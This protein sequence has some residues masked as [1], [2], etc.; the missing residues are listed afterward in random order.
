MDKLNLN[1]LTIIPNG[2]GILAMYYEYI[3]N[4]NNINY[5]IAPLYFH[6]G[7]YIASSIS[8]KYKILSF[9]IGLS[10]LLPSLLFETTIPVNFFFK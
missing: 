3:S 2:F 4:N 6:I 7:F 1:L 9:I 5:I 10:T 8:N